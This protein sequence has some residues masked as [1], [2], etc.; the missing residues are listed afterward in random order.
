LQRLFILLKR[1]LEKHLPVKL[2]RVAGLGVYNFSVDVHWVIILK[3]REASM[4]F[5]NENT[6]GPPVDG[7]AVALVE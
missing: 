3:R 5:V 2:F 1:I 7:A 6:K 4:H